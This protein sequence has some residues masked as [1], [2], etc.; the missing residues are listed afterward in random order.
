MLSLSSPYRH[1]ALFLFTLLTVNATAQEEN[2]FAV[3]AQLRTRGEINNGALY[4]RATKEGA[5]YFANERARL[6]LHYTRARLQLK[7][8]AQHTGVWGQDDIKSRNGR[9]AM[10]EAWVRLNLWDGLSAQVGR[11]QLSYDDERLLGTLDWNVAGNWHDAA[12][13]IYEHKHMQAHAVITL[14]QSAENVRGHFQS[15]GGM[16][17]KA[18]AMLWWHQDFDVQP[19]G[20]SLLAMNLSLEAGAQGTAKTKHMQTWGTHIT[21]HP[22]GYNAA[23]SFY[24]QTGEEKSGKS[25]SAFMGSLSGDYTINTDWTVRAGYDYLSGNDG[26]N[27]NQHAFNPLYG[28]HHKFYGAMDYFTGLVDCGLQDIHLGGTTH[29]TR[30]VTLSLDYHALLTAEPIGQRSKMLGH[31]LDLHASMPLQKDVTVTAGYSRMFGT[32]TMDA[33]LGGNHSLR[34][35]WL[36]L[37][38]NVNPRILFTKW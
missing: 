37:Q 8:S 31:E 17:Y 38:L 4:P 32:S 20:I 7:V 15:A 27:I 14:N 24:F 21:Y 26:R 28:T 29:L 13:L 10:N 25:V 2:Q 30:P 6:S 1:I 11:Q 36:W 3:D 23:A 22:G 19:V 9:V 35:D 34:Q 5:S 12:K 33:F 16:P 18:L